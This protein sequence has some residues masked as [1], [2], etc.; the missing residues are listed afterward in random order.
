MRPLGTSC[1]LQTRCGDRMCP[2]ATAMQ[3]LLHFAY[4]P[5]RPALP[6]PVQNAAVD[7]SHSG[8]TS[9]SR[10][11]ALQV[12][13]LRHLACQLLHAALPTGLLQDFQ[14]LQ[15]IN[16]CLKVSPLKSVH[17]AVS[18]PAIMSENRLQGAP[19]H[20]YSALFIATLTS[21]YVSGTPSTVQGCH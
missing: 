15:L 6:C 16:F 21:L 12:A 13:W 4:A 18:Y 14:L 20:S 11:A 7:A 2:R 9:S 5:C 1:T 3:A 17:Q 10:S 8:F 19:I